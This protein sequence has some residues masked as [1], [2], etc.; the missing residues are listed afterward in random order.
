[1]NGQAFK[2]LQIQGWR[3]FHAIDV[4]L[5]PRLTIIT[6]ANGAGKS[7]IL[8]FFTRHFGYHRNFL[9]VPKTKAG[10]VSF[11]FG[12]FEA[13]KRSLPLLRRE[14]SQQGTHI[15]QI[16]Y[17]SGAVGRLFLPPSQGLHYSI[18]IN[19]EQHVEGLHIDSH[20]PPNIYRHVSQIS[21]TPPSVVDVG[22]GLNQEYVNYYA[23]GQVHQGS[24]HHIK[25][26]LI[27][28]SIFGHGNSTME[29][30][31]EL[32]RLFNGFEDKLRDILPSSLGFER[33]IIRSPEVL[34]STKSGDFLIDA[35]SG[36]VI[37][38]VEVAWQIYFY[39]QGKSGFVI[40]F[41]EP[42]NHLHPSMQK[43]FL[44]NI[45]RAFPSTQ[46]IVVTHSPFIIS[47]MRDS[48]VYVLRYEDTTIEGVDHDESIKGLMGS[49]VY[50]ERLDTVNKAGSASEILRDVLGITTTIP[51]WAED[52]VHQIVQSFEGSEFNQ[53]ALKRLYTQLEQEGLASS[54]PAAIASL[55]RP[56]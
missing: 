6:G 43:S 4:E 31:P 9:A 50:A 16:E 22:N 47:A 36:G 33:L 30:N 25:L 41:D 42:E 13:I 5:H 46:I 24:L 12:I 28:M 48:Y 45:M 32:I 14:N 15:G 29:P 3:Q 26:S 38:L 49:R 37:K 56:K 23:S 18:Q 1:M 8:S 35:A 19:Q 20:R 55:T 44:P 10:I 21:A 7:T 52:R 11:T 40:T 39:S 54:Y 2:R 34:L 27:Q 51:D 17:T 53:A